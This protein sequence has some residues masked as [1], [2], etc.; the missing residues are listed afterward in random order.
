[1][2]RQP[3]IGVLVPLSL[4]G[5][6][7]LNEAIQLFLADT[8][9]VCTGRRTCRFCRRRCL[10]LGLVAQYRQRLLSVQLMPKKGAISV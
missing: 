5:Q 2:I 3:Q 7:P 4:P 10:V 6:D 8:D 9:A 1:M